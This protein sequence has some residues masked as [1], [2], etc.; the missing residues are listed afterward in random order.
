MEIICKS[1][2]TVNEYRTE[3][4]SNNL[5]AYC[6]AC[7]KYI[8]NI[9]YSEPALHFGKYNGSKIKD[10]VQ[11]EEVNYL[12]WCLANVRLAANLKQA[13]QFHLGVKP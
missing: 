13:I 8:K 6:T 11:P 2:G 5:V 1:C 4:K 10:L 9:P 12:H 7:G 3:K